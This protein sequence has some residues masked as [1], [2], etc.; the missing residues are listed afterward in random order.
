MSD[1][2]ELDELLTELCDALLVP[3]IDNHDRSEHIDRIDSVLTFASSDLHDLLRTARNKLIEDSQRDPMWF[4]FDGSRDLRLQLSRCLQV[5]LSG[6]GYLYH[7][8]VHGRLAMILKTGLDP[9]AKRV[10][11]DKEADRRNLDAAVFFDTTWRGATNWAHI[12][13]IRSRGPRSS[14]KRKPVVLRI[15]RGDLEVARD[16]LATAPGC[17]FIKGPV[18]VEGAEVLREPF[19]GF[20]RWEPIEQCLVGSQS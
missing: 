10:W 15:A 11:T 1:R 12:A 14:W 4:A 18:S 19:S 16:P 9:E 20:P 8:T 17:V 13:S 5:H 2:S 7:G 6:S 3:S